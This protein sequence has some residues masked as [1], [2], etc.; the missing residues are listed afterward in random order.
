MEYASGLSQYGLY[1]IVSILA[2][3]IIYLYKRTV[4]MEK[5]IKDTM[6]EQANALLELNKNQAEM[7]AT[8]KR[9]IE[10]C[11]ETIGQVHGVLESNT[12]AIKSMTETLSSLRDK[13]E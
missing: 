7:I 3:V 6:K 9:T 10:D 12:R 8:A 5:D 2:S 4:A 13:H 11:N 1:A